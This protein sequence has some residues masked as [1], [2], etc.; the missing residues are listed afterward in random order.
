MPPIKTMKKGQTKK[1]NNALSTPQSDKLGEL[2]SSSSLRERLRKFG[3]GKHELSRRIV[4]LDD[5]PLQPSHVH[6]RS[7]PH[8]CPHAQLKKLFRELWALL[9]EAIMRGLK[10]V[11]AIVVLT[12]NISDIR[13]IAPQ[14]HI[15]ASD[16]A[17]ERSG[18]PHANAPAVTVILA[19]LSV[20]LECLLTSDLPEIPMRSPRQRISV[21]A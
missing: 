12:Q 20:P 21:G 4:L 8:L 6:L 2:C 3:L 14:M 9:L 19:D 7:S 11:A 13:G 1:R 18:G 17:D 10:V 15:V 16:L 5:D